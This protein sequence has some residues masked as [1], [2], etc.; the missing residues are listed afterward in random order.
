MP[1]TRRPAAAGDWPAVWPMLAARGSHDGEA[2]AH[3]RFLRVLDDPM[4]LVVLAAD[5]DGAVVGYAAAQDHGDHL[6]A[7]KEGRVARLHDMYVDPAHRRTGAGRALHEAVVQW[8][9]TR[10]RYLQWQA[11]EHTAAPFYERLGYLGRP[12]PQPDH[13]E[14]EVVFR[15]P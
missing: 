2:S 12:C 7:G 1:P 11:H 13:P 4:W 5:G 6:R 10:V 14:F 9:S 8:A 3:A 15:D